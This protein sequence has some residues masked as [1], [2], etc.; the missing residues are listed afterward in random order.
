MIA[1]LIMIYLIFGGNQHASSLKCWKTMIFR[2]SWKSS[3]TYYE[4][5]NDNLRSSTKI[6]EEFPIR[7][8]ALRVPGGNQVDGLPPARHS[9]TR[10]KSTE[11]FCTLGLFGDVQVWENHNDIKI[12]YIQN[13]LCLSKFHFG[14][15]RTTSDNANEI[16]VWLQISG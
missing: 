15:V 6:R 12:S 16:S 14:W 8:S 7:W 3:R 1:I 4:T 5:G 10:P 2:I 13:K 9:N 11:F